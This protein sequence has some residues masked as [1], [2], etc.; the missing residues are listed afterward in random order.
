MK[1]GGRNSIDWFKPQ[2]IG[3]ANPVRINGSSL[4]TRSV[5]VFQILGYMVKI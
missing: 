4:L 3:L 1:R 2:W 5:V